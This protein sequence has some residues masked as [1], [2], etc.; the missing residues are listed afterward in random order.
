[1]IW[2]THYVALQRIPCYRNA[3]C[4]GR[5]VKPVFSLDTHLLRCSKMVKRTKNEKAKKNS[6]NKLA[7]NLKSSKIL[8]PENRS[9][10]RVTRSKSIQLEIAQKENKNPTKIPVKK[11]FQ[12]NTRSK[13]N[14]PAYNTRKKSEKTGAIVVDKVSKEQLPQTSKPKT[15]QTTKILSVLDLHFTK[16]SDF[17]VNSIVLAKQKYS[18]PWP[19]KVERIEKNRVLVYFFGDKRFGYVKKTEIYDFVLSVNAVK[20]VIAS[21]TIKYYQSYVTGIAEVEFLLGIASADSF[22]I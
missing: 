10:R 9:N 14:T 17:E 20:S 6:A 4:K 16:L 18:T 11:K 19:S 2:S 3:A 15:K 8:A 5:T 13:A 7:P 1:M 21:K 22:F 12:V